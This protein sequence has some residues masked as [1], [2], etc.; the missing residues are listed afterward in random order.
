MYEKS[1]VAK[2]GDPDYTIRVGAWRNDLNS[3]IR[4]EQDEDAVFIADARQARKVI[5]AIRKAA[6]CFGWEDV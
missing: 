1:I 2:N 5:E 3:N 6:K 4:I